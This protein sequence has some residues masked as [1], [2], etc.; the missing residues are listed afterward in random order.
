M[1]A[2]TMEQ[3]K[4]TLGTVTYKQHTYTQNL[5]HLYKP[6]DRTDCESYM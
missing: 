6:A 2:R 3:K 5:L 4:E 1:N